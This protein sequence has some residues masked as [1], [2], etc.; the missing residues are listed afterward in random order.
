MNST[1]VYTNIQ[2]HTNQK[3]ADKLSMNIYK[4][5]RKSHLN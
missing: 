1:K 4:K 5:I 2:I 3:F